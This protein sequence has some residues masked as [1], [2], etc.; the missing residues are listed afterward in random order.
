MDESG[1]LGGFDKLVKGNRRNALN[2]IALM[3]VP[4]VRHQY[5]GVWLR[6]RRSP[7]IL[8]RVGRAAQ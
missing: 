8:H 1:H 6:N 3:S 2:S 5:R 7:W 4:N